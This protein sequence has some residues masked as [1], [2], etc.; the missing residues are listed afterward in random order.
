M[1]ITESALQHNFAAAH[2]VC[3]CSSEM[4]A[5]L[6]YVPVLYPAAARM[7]DSMVVTDPLPLVPATWTTGRA[8]WGL[9]TASKRRCILVCYT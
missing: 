7:Q 3:S 4:H 8:A 5:Y 2:T 1:A 9:P 6:V